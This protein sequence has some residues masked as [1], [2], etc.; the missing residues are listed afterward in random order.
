MPADRP[1]WIGELGRLAGYIALF[2][3][4]A[5][6]LSWVLE[7][8]GLLASSLG[9]ALAALAAGVVAIR[10]FDGRP[11][12]A[13]GVA[14]T[15]AV[16]RELV[17]GLAV[18]G[19]A[20]AAIAGLLA[21]L[22]T[23]SYQAQAG[24]AADW[25]ATVGGDFALL[26]VAAFAEEALFR[27]YGFQ[28]LVRAIGPAIATVGAS[29]LF[30]AAHA[31]N[32]NVDTFALVNIFLAGILLSA[33]YLRTRSLWF[34]TAVHLGW[35]WCMAS[36]LDLPVSG[37]AMFDTPLY[38][39]VVGGP[40]WLTGGAFGPEGGLAATAAFVLAALAVWRL[41]GLDETEEM[42]ALGPLVDDPGAE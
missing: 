19:L 1:G 20:L 3:A 28:V 39:P 8:M 13:V 42:R 23:L 24:T 30:A 7:P 15:R 35:N 25:A 11:A 31:F 22:G 27:G 36:L 41:P 34:A 38:E 10:V 9:V 4:I 33:A 6:A 5:W 40:D 37:L 26:A 16:P 29:A 2:I 14:W 17:V 32:P 12:G 21:A 18:G